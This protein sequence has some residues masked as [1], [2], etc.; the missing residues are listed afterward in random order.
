MK[1]FLML[2]ILCVMQ[3]IGFAQNP[4]I[5]YPHVSV[6]SPESASMAVDVDYP[7]SL[8]TGVPNINIPLYTLEVDGF[9]LPLN[10][11]YHAS[12]IRADQEASWVGLG[13]MLDVG[14]RIS[15][16]I[17]HVDD[18]LENGWDR[19]YPYCT[20]GWYDGPT[21]SYAN[22]SL[23]KMVGRNDPYAWVAIERC[24][25]TDSEPDLFFYNLPSCNGKFIFDKNKLPVLFNKEHNLKVVVNRVGQ[26]ARVQLVVYDSKGNQYVFND[27]EETKLYIANK[28]LNCNATNPQ[29]KFDDKTSNFVE[30]TPIRI[31][32]EEVMEPGPVDPYPYT[33]CWCVTKII[34]NKNRVIN[35]TYETENQELP[36]QESC[37]VYNSS[38]G[39]NKLYTRSKV[40]N[41]ALRL[42]NITWDFGRVEFSAGN[43][44]DIKG[45]AKYL[46]KMTVYNQNGDMVKS[47]S[48]RYSY[49]NEDIDNEYDYVFKRLRLDALSMNGIPN[50][51]VFEYYGGD[52]PAKNTK[53]VDYWGYPNGRDY[54]DNYCVGVFTGVEKD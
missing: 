18:F 52:M 39:A 11:K 34:T 16:T 3:E 53:N 15:R 14:A 46:S 42:K 38:R 33:S 51:Y 41:K 25:T 47:V 29:N 36:T 1:K 7:V 22:E 45:N 27:E 50:D 30:W 54:G 20:T 43:R 2:S 13:W 17:K 44:E 26:P 40:V 12:G 8:Y 10:L 24:L 49:F 5:A 28:P 35:F 19:Y 6:M 48:F 21:F 37:E 9:Q 31:G 4:D 23:Y 32:Y